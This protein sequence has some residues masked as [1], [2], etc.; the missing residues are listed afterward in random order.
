M[1]GD[2]EFVADASKY[3]NGLMEARRWL[4][5]DAGQGDET[6]VVWERTTMMRTSRSRRLSGTLPLACHV[7]PPARRS[8]AYRPCR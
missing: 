7:P 3:F 1:G 4:M 8:T 6:A 5:P 2:A